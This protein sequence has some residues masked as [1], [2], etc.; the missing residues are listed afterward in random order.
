MI[1]KTYIMTK[2]DPSVGINGETAEVSLKFDFDDRAHREQ[3]RAELQMCFSSIFGER[4]TAIFEDETNEDD[5]CGDH[6]DIVG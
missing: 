3:V 1:T 4:A 6:D 5:L 2:G